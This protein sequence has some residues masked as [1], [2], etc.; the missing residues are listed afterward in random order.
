VI[1][2]CALVTFTR[3]SSNWQNSAGLCLQVKWVSDDDPSKGFEYLYL[4]DADYRAYA[5]RF[6][7]DDLPFAAVEVPGAA[8]DAPSHWRLT[9]VIGEEAGLG[10][11]CLSGSG[12]VAAAFARA[13]EEGFT[14][15]LVSGRTVGI[16]AY[17]ARLGHRCARLHPRQ[18]SSGR[19]LMILLSV[20]GGAKVV[21]IQAVVARTIG[22]PSHCLLSCSAAFVP[23][24]NV[25]RSKRVSTYEM[26]CSVIQRSDQPVILTGFQALNKLLGRTIYTSQ[27]QLGGPQIMGANGV[28]H[29]TA[30]DDLDGVHA[31]LR[32]LSYLPRAVGRGARVEASPPAAQA[33][34]ADA[35]LDRPIS[36]EPDASGRFNVRHAITGSPPASSASASPPRQS[37]PGQGPQGLFDRDSW[38]ECQ[39]GWARTVVTGR[40]RLGGLP[41]GVLG[42]ETETVALS[43]PAD[44][45]L[46]SS[47]EQTIMQAGG[48]RTVDY[49]HMQLP[50]T[51]Q[52]TAVQRLP[53]SSAG[54]GFFVVCFST[55][56]VSSKRTSKAMLKT[57][58]RCG[59]PT[60]PRRPR[61]RSRNSAA[62][63]CR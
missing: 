19:V 28:S 48:V 15:T 55:Q 39:A 13:Y 24:D 4:A 17:L 18:A 16:G 7:P 20:L 1:A 46:P 23:S 51:V 29:L 26:S 5:A 41:V 25:R 3:S 31:I 12:A 34:E 42:V 21:T 27:L 9:D 33:S 47:S 58:C 43:L 50:R 30:R 63:A 35:D 52:P 45:G 62:R 53:S 2:C 6:A 59:T 38:V 60:R 32:W 37:G 36:Y 61:R 44:P 56:A 54:A 40:A 10:V 57:H 8:G 22:L 14:V 11:E 49:T